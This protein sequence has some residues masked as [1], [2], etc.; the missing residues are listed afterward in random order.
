MSNKPRKTPANKPDGTMHF[1]N[2]EALIDGEG[3]IT[4]GSVA[5]I[6]CVA[7]AADHNQ[8]LAML[9]RRSGES[10]Q[11]LLQRLDSA[12][13]SAYDDENYIDEVNAPAA[14]PAPLKKRTAKSRR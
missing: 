1:E 2:I 14:P 13:A 6:P 11:D 12:I 7:T 4:I 8:C 9:V 3:D 10:L 5:S